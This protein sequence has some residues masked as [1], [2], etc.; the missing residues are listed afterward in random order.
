VTRTLTTAAAIMLAAIT[1][2]QA[3][4]IRNVTPDQMSALAAGYVAY[5]AE[6]HCAKSLNM[7]DAVT[8]AVKAAGLYGKDFN[9]S[10]EI[11][12]RMRAVFLDHMAATAKATGLR[13]HSKYDLC[14]ML[15]KTFG[16]DGTGIKGPV[17][18]SP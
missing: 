16:P 17:E 5:Q 18:E 15:L 13:M 3:E 12:H 10:L 7:T 9:F 14:L 2:A 1:T 8:D 11:E 4:K 6:Q